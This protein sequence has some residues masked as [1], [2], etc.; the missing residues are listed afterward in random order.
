MA[1]Y[2]YSKYERETVIIG[3]D[4]ENVVN[5]ST[6]QAVWRRRLLKLAEARPDDVKILKQDED[7]LEVEVPKRFLKITPPRFI[8]DEQREASRQRLLE[9]RERQK[10]NSL[11]EAEIADMQSIEENLDDDID[12]EVES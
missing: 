6:Y 10:N 3:N 1:Q 5:I 7:Y 8:S 9:Y 12:D 4:A 2:K 11:S